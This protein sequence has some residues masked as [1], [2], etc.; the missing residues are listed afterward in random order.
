[1]NICFIGA[2]GHAYAVAE[3][4]KIKDK[5]NTV[6]GI[7]AGSEGENIEGLYNYLCEAGQSPKKYDDW[8]CMLDELKPD[9]AIVDNHYGEHA[10]VSIAALERGCHVLSEKPLA[11]TLDSLSELK[12]AHAKSNKKISAMFT[13]RF[14]ADFMTAKKI[15]QDGE[16][17]DIRLVNAQKSY[18]LGSRPDFYKSKASFG[19]FIPWVGIHAIDAIYYFTSKRFVYADA[20]CSSEGNS[21]YGDLEVTAVGNFI[22]E[23]NILSTMTA[24]YLRPGEAPSHG[25]NRVRIVGS[26]GILEIIRDKVILTDKDGE[27][28]IDLLDKTDMFAAFIDYIG[29]DENS[30]LKSDDS[31]HVTETALAAQVSADQKNKNGGI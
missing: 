14:D 6:V 7:A 30:P 19:G 9:I 27:R 12:A 20:A 1:M 17:G 25:D 24:D 13:M 2:S 31:F 8:L 3:S 11:T 21:G 4:E 16:I 15:I 18:K 5:S 22:S 23:G 10:K 29:G 26:A 28:E